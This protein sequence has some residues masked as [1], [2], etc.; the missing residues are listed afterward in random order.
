M[1]RKTLFLVLLLLLISNTTALA[2]EQEQEQKLK[3]LQKFTTNYI[4]SYDIEKTGETKIKQNV[5]IINSQKDVVVTNYSLTV[6]RMGIYDITTSIENKDITP[7]ISENNNQT[8]IK[9]TIDNP[10]IGKNKINNLQIE[11]RTFDIAN[12]IGEIWTVNIPKTTLLET[13]QKYDVSVRIPKSFGPEIYVSP[14]PIKKVEESDEIVYFF[15]KDSLLRTGI[16]ASFGNFQVLNFKLDYEL[17]NN[18]NFSTTKEIALPPDILDIQQVTYKKLTPT[19][20]KLKL[21]V[22]G[23]TIAVYKLLGKENL[24]VHLIGT[25]RILGK[26]IKP[27]YGLSAKQIPKNLITQ[28]TKESEFWPTNSNQIKEIV[29]V[30]FEKDKS[31]TQNAQKAYFFTTNNLSYDFEI[32]KKDFVKRKGALLALAENDS[33]ACMEFT[34]LFITIVRAMGIPARQLNGYAI[35]NETDG[36][37]KMPLSI[38]LKGGDLLHSWAEFYDE[39]FGWVPVD[40]TWGSTSGVDYF[41]KLDTNHFVFSINGTTDDSPPPAGAYKFSENERLQVEARGLPTK[42]KKQVSVDFAQTISENDFKPNIGFEKITSKNPFSILKGD[43]VFEITNNGITT[44]YI[45]NENNSKPLL[46]TQKI[47]KSV[48]P[49]GNIKYKDATRK[50][51]TFTNPYKEISATEKR[52][53]IILIILVMLLLYMTFRV[54]SNRLKHP[55]TLLDHL[56][57]HLQDQDL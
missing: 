4:T 52:N 33:N 10:A 36:N 7:E 8:V 44:I 14:E 13:T 34:D 15:Q 28:Y 56:R 25:A 57:H 43:H 40:P 46:P 41:T 37:T 26:Q 17:Q 3:N 53:I 9:A 55:K 21:D 38:N 31:A 11:Y 30:L 48:K 19:P 2:Q 24:N 47:R 32:L 49:G 23:N 45:L 27:E 35:V 39:E 16:A 51:Y 29:D 18:S 5:E 50:E 1:F 12:K 6:K 42:N 20:Q 22:D 54:L